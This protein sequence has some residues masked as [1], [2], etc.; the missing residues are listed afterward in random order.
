MATLK[1]IRLI[2]LDLDDTLWPCAPVIRQA[3]IAHHEWLRHRAAR[4]AEAHDVESLRAHRREVMRT[5]PHL[6]H[7][8]TAVRLRSL[9]LL[10]AQFGYPA[11]LADQATAVFRQ[12]RNRVTPYPEVGAVLRALRQ[13]YWLVS[14]TNGNCQ[15]EHTP[16]ADHF[17]LTL[18]AAETGAAKPDP[19]LFR[20]ALARTGVEPA[21]ALHVGDDPELDVEAARRVGMATA[22]VNR[23]NA[24]WPAALAPPDHRLRE[25]GTLPDLLKGR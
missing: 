16:L 19:A 24:P 25:L 9:A 14:V 5:H 8:F 17:H 7:D 21:Q 15:V 11:R 6:A 10:L 3:E 20:H 22:W 23:T 2:T 13:D 18:S 4:L 12:A 1:P